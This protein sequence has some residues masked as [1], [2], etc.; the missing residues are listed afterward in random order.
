MLHN[1]IEILKNQICKDFLIKISTPYYLVFQKADS[2]H[3]T[4]PGFSLISMAYINSE[5]GC[6]FVLKFDIHR[7]IN[8]KET[9]VKG[10]LK[11]Q[12]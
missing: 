9:F 2:Y 12:L 1:I 4:G 5:E 11:A 10:F 6:L 3:I 8:H 7:L